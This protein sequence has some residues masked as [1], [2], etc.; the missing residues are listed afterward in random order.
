M[1]SET[2]IRILKDSG[3][4][5]LNEENTEIKL[6]I[7]KLGKA[8]RIRKNLTDRENIQNYA[9]INESHKFL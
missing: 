5:H 4:S 2:P 6:P 7:L 9:N 1:V 8:K 3:I